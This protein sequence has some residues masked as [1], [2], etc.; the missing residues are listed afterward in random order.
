M[1]QPLIVMAVELIGL[2]AWRL[3]SAAEAC[4]SSVRDGTN[5]HLAVAIA[6][7]LGVLASTKQFNTHSEKFI[8]ERL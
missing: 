4:S 2:E 5:W 8:L 1:T 6:A 7:K 3:A